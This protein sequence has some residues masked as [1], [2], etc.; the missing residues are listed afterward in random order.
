[1]SLYYCPALH[2]KLDI[3]YKCVVLYQLT[4]QCYSTSHLL[5]CFVCCKKLNYYPAIICG[6]CIININIV[7]SC[8]AAL[9]QCVLCSIIQINMNW[10]NLTYSA[11]ISLYTPND[12]LIWQTPDVDPRDSRVHQR[13]VGEIFWMG[14]CLVILDKRKY[15][16]I[17]CD[18]I[19]T[20]LL[21]SD[22]GTIS[23]WNVYVFLLT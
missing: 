23:F 12:P 9:K 7:M 5:D 6:Y 14:G 16:R 11:I 15:L 8:K 19:L 20:G 18:H 1:M 4:I 2:I 13:H 17:G 10:L 21:T 3:Y 22:C